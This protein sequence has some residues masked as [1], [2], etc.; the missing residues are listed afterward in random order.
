MSDC[1]KTIYLAAK[2]DPMCDTFWIPVP[3]YERNPDGSL[4]KMHYEGADHYEE[5][6]E[7]ID[8]QEYDIK[9]RRPD[10]IFTFSPY[11][12][13]GVL[14]S[15]HPD[16]YCEKLRDLTDLLVY[17][18][19]F[20]T[21]G[22]ITDA[23]TQC[24]GVLQAHLV[25]L[26]SE[27]VKNAYVRD[28]MEF[29]KHG[30][31]R[32][33]YGHPKDKFVVLGSPK[34]D[35]VLS[36]KPDDFTLPDEWLKIM[37]NQDETRK[38]AVFY[39]TSIFTAL[40]NKE[41]YLK[42]IRS[43]FETFKTRN[44][45]I[46]WWRPHPL[47]RTAYSGFHTKLLAEYDQIVEDYKN[48]GWGIYDDSP[49]LHRAIACTDMYYGDSSSVALLYEK[50]G[51]PIVYQDVNSSY[52]FSELVCRIPET[53]SVIDNSLYYK[54]PLCNTVL[55]FDIGTCI[56]SYSFSIPNTPIF[57]Q[58]WLYYQSEVIDG[59]IYFIP[60]FRDELVIYDSRTGICR[61]ARLELQDEYITTGKGKF[62]GIL[63]CGDLLF[64]LPQYYSSIIAYDIKTS[65][66]IHCLDLK[67]VFPR[68]D[69]SIGYFWRFEWL[70]FSRILLPAVSENAVL[71]FDLDD[72]SYIIHT[73]G[74]DGTKLG[75]ITLYKNYFWVVPINKP[76]IIKWDH[77]ENTTDEFSAFPAG[78]DKEIS[79]KELFIGWNQTIEYKSFLFLFPYHNNKVCRFDMENSVFEHLEEFD[80]YCI[81]EEGEADI[82]LFLFPCLN[83]KRIYIWSKA[84]ILLEYDLDSREIR[85][86]TNL[87]DLSDEDNKKLSLDFFDS[88]MNSIETSITKPIPDEADYGNAGKSIYNYV[89]N[90]I[91]GDK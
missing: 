24:A 5:G 66:T 8:W 42:K 82:A 45:I 78:Y 20:V 44:D 69:N 80:R 79:S 71:E 28:Y 16:Y 2:A 75:D 15:I 32:T 73:V 86:H 47:I 56:P 34:Y 88:F 40:N 62:M 84:K 3:Y 22:A 6:I 52:A 11:D 74:G 14:T 72:Y 18:P 41:L 51:K 68:A 39:N 10:V 43:V 81:R 9:T 54:M 29:E 50:T 89:K 4:G 49:D 65:K 77:S 36:S 25:V 21:T 59:K 57:G 31:S 48:A 12:D 46:L 61:T 35:A 30:Y 76:K 33:V 7:C 67:S 1:I 91:L 23:Y 63:Q 60:Y 38:K 13:L 19:Y 70:S 83:G 87:F 55:S 85:E 17:V 58:H 27:E 53:L 37:T 26:E 90:R 64:L